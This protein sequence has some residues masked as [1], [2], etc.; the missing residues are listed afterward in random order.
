MF[1][2]AAALWL[3]MASRMV[4]KECGM[5]SS[6]CS[7]LAFT[8]KRLVRDYGSASNQTLGKLS[9]SGTVGFADI[10][11]CFIQPVCYK[12]SLLHTLMSE[13]PDFKYVLSSLIIQIRQ[14]VEVIPVFLMASK[15]HRSAYVYFSLFFVVFQYFIFIYFTFSCDW[16]FLGEVEKRSNSVIAA[17]AEMA[18]AGVNHALSLEE[19]DD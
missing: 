17:R 2:Q 5:G 7:G 13:R 6:S 8:I 16:T 18:E 14:K 4:S 10:N 1:S 12:L 11:R 9:I 3:N 19:N 15:S